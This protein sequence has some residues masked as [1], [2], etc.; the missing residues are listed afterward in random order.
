MPPHALRIFRSIVALLALTNCLQAFPEQ[1]QHDPDRDHAGATRT[2]NPTIAEKMETLRRS[3]NG[4][5]KVRTRCTSQEREIEI[6]ETTE[7]VGLSGCSL[8]LRT[9]KIT[10]RG[11]HNDRSE[12]DLTVYAN[13]A[14][15]TTPASVQPQTFSQ[16]KSVDGPVL[17]VMSRAEPGKS[18]R[19]A[20]RSTSPNPTEN[21]ET[22]IRRNDLSYFFPDEAK[23]KKAARALDQ[24]VRRCGGK[25]WPDEDDLP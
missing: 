21:A 11:S 8:T 2:D 12:L 1:E 23:A 7:I 24:A 19:A 17:K 13:L 6:E 20:R 16:C 4:K 10:T 5:A 14:D 25:E 15:L 18:L 22:E 9:R 3:V